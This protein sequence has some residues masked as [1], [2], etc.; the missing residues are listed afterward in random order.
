M[1][2]FLALL[3]GVLLTLGARAQSSQT[4][5]NLSLK[6][7]TLEQQMHYSVYLPAGYEFSRKTYPILYLLHGMGDN[8]TAW[9]RNG[10]IQQIT[11]KA[12]SLGQIDPVVIIM[13]DAGMS[14]YMNSIDGKYLY[15]DY[16]F[17]E[18]MPYIEHTYRIT[19]G[20]RYRSIAGQSMG[21][22]GALLYAFHRPDLFNT[23]I[24]L[25]PGI[26]TDEQ[27]NQLSAPDYNQRYQIPL[28]PAEPDTPRIT[29]YYRERYSILHL[30][31]RIPDKLKNA[32]RLY[33]D[34]GDDDY[35]YKGNSLLHILLRDR[36]I[37][38]EYRVRNG[39]HNWKYWR[40]GIQ[41]GLLYMQN[42]IR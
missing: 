7:R 36:H 39:G 25:S 27:I 37:P 38:H 42:G 41:D 11:D 24:A 20:K 29:E 2:R 15:E 26:R 33:I 31:S 4:L 19:A 23:C 28:G 17:H 35:L 8:H 5:D 32:V 6:S 9:I 21:G 18:L 12:I 14:Y 10:Q 40:E 16:F 30:T 34:C 3:L 22:Y 13:P 1:K